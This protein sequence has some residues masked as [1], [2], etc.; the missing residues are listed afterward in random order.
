MNT[1]CVC[2]KCSTSTSYNRDCFLCTTSRCSY[3]R[4]NKVKSSSYDLKG[5][6]IIDGKSYRFGA[7]KAQASGQGKM[8]Q[9]QEYFYFHRV[10][11]MDAAATTGGATDFDPKELEA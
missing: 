10:E 5:N 3:V 4:T 11:P 2:C 9:G 6:I 7:Y 8:A 1:N